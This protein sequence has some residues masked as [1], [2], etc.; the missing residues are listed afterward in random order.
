MTKWIW[1]LTPKE[2]VTQQKEL[3][4]RVR[5][6]PFPGRPELIAGVDIS[7]NRFSPRVFA[8]I[9]VLRQSDLSVVERAGEEMDVAFPYVPG[10]LSYREIPPLLKAWSRLRSKPDLVV[11]DGQGI[12]HPRRLGVASH[13]G[14][15][16]DKPTIGCA[17]S[18]LSGTFD[19][20]GI[21]AGQR[22]PLMDGRERIGTV[23][24]SKTGCKPLFIS[25]GHLMDHASAV[26][27]IMVLRAGYRLPEPTRQAHL[28]VNELRVQSRRS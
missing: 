8:G 18:R 6:Q 11:V 12:A 15:V 20:P 7:F 28:F 19:E 16:L 23:L 5:L 25:P 27:L 24:R 13:L 26:R 3:R 10:L 21:E 9:V 4:E 22:T 2:A 17:K 1:N 14:L